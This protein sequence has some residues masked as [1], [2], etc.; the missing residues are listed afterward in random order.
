M[1]E[2]ARLANASEVKKSVRTF[3]GTAGVQ[4]LIHSSSVV[5]GVSVIIKWNDNKYETVHYKASFRI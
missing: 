3:K 1:P 4:P 2:V 5:D